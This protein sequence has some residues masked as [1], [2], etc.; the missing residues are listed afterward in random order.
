MKLFISSL[1]PRPSSLPR[2]AANPRCVLNAEDNYT[3]TI[4]ITVY[5]NQLAYNLSKFL[6]GRTGLSLIT[7]SA[8]VP[9]DQTNFG[10]VLLSS[11]SEGL[12]HLAMLFV[13]MNLVCA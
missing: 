3:A 10:I 9:C 6:I 5:G 11:P 8:A 1:G 7:A 12:H 13:L 2:W 4:Q